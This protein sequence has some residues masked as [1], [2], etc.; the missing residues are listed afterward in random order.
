MVSLFLAAPFTDPA[1]AAQFAAVRAALDSDTSTDSLLLGNLVL[2]DGAAPLDAVVVRPHSIALLVLVP[3][4]GVL[5]I[6]ALGYG[7]WQLG[8]VP[9]AGSDG[10][11]NPFEQFRQQKTLLESWL[12]PRFTPAQANL[13]FISGVVVFEAP[14]TFGP[15]VEAALNDAPTG[16]QLVAG[17]A[18]LPRRLRQL[19]TPEIDLTA[20]DLAEWAAEL[21]EFAAAVPPDAQTHTTVTSPGDLSDAAAQPAGSFLGGK[22][23]ALWGWL[24]ANDIPDDDLPYGAASSLMARNEEKQQLEQLRQQMQADISAQLQA[25]ETREAERERSI[26]QLRAE[27]AQAPPVAAEATALVSRLGAETREKAALEAEME[28]SR[29]ELA[30]RNQELDAKIQ[31]LSQLIGQ[32]SAVPVAAAPAVP[33]LPATALEPGPAL[34]PEP[35]PAAPMAPAFASP[36]AATKAE[37]VPVG[38]KATMA[39]DEAVAPAITAVEGSSSHGPVSA[40]DN[41]TPVAKAAP[42]PAAAPVTAA[43]PAAATEPVADRLRAFGKRAQAAGAGALPHLQQLGAAARARHRVL[44]GAAG[45]VVVVL[46]VWMFVHRSG[47]APV[48]YQENGRWGYADAGGAPVIKAQFASAAPFQDGQAVVEQDGAFGLVDEDGK[49]VVAPAYDAINPYHGGFARVR[50]G[51][52]YTFLEKDGQEFD[53]FF[54]NALDFA[55]GHAAVLDHRGWFYISGPEVP[56]SPPMFREAYSF[57]DGLARVRL[58][59]GY[60]FITPDYLTDPA[61]GTKPFGRYKLAADFVDGKARVTQNGRSFLINKDGEEVK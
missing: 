9:L 36:V 37:P 6:P 28:A 15:D 26:S 42:A 29:A 10:F 18:E 24:G 43:L 3:R 16:F 39:P 40:E 54:F 2:E 20:A 51:E 32:L 50:V 56:D 25:L 44:L 41:P 19:A 7:G 31:Q 11:D 21:N 1:R 30:A 53:H 4:G 13:Q 49:Q 33:V 23:R 14:L 34:A 59:D 61:S 46:L 5:G 60:T 55:E 52:A 48:P 45:A 8:S 12:G 22:A 58:P 38:D 47:T 27:L 17:P 35:A 57:V